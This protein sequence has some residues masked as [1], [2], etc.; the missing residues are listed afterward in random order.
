MSV[1]PAPASGRGWPVVGQPVKGSVQRGYRL[2]GLLPGCIIALGLSRDTCPCTPITCPSA[3]SLVKGAF[4]DAASVTSAE[5]D[6]TLIG[7]HHT[8]LTLSK[9]SSNI[10]ERLYIRVLKCGDGIQC[11]AASSKTLPSPPYLPT[12]RR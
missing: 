2:S 4:W 3:T 5:G 6:E 1:L 8:A 7:A 9:V 11:R 10:L 12:A